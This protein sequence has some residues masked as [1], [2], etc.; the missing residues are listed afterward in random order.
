MVL[1]CGHISSNLLSAIVSITLFSVELC[2]LLKLS[3]KT[4]IKFV[5]LQSKR[6][7]KKNS[8]FNPFS[9]LYDVK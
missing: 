6:N 5:G 2:G 7:I 8:N 3:Y 4:H 1:I 9:Q